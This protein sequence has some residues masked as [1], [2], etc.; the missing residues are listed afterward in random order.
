MSANARTLPV[1]ETLAGGVA[2]PAREGVRL[3]RPDAARLAKCALTVIPA[4]ILLIVVMAAD[5]PSFLSATTHSHFFPGW[6]AGPL[7]GLWPGLTRNPTTLKDIF[8]GSVIVMYASYVV[9]LRHGEQLRTAT[10]VAAVLVIH[11]ILFVAPPLTLTD[12]FNYINYGRMEAI[13]SLNPYTTIPILEPHSDSSFVLSNWHHLLSPYGPLFTL[14]SFA[15]VPLGVAGSFWAFK[16]ILM[17]ASLA[18]IMLVYRCAQLLGR[19][20]KQA[21]MFVGL[22]PIVLMW[23]LGGDHNDFIMVF[24]IVLGFYLLLLARRSRS[25]DLIAASNGHAPPNSLGRALSPT[26]GAGLAE[27]VRAWLGRPSTLLL[28]AGGTFAVAVFV[29]ASAG[30]VIPV[31]LAGLAGSPRRCGRVL[32]GMLVACVLVVAMSLLAFGPHLPDLSTQGRVV[33]NF[34]LPNLLGLALG[35]GGETNMLRVLLSVALIG[36][37][38]ACCVLAYRRRESLTATGWATVALLVTL[39]WVLPWYV[40]W[41]APLAALSG[42][43]R[44]RTVTLVLGAYLMLAWVPSAAGFFSAIGFNPAKTP[45]GAQH[46]RAVKELL[47]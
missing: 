43:R 18:T 36:A 5:R 28:G 12:I 25:P 34:G 44:L 10:V 33:T 1:R 16:A 39:S 11:M 3:L 46:Q 17:G 14:L 38:L 6:M 31:V 15:V 30:I 45:L 47:N 4:L 8:T 19:D 23:G 42:S 35:Q 22:N 40:V 29:K 13:H 20:P 7:G 32:L 9:V 26:A 37:T 41:L 21:I 2:L 27:R 24:F